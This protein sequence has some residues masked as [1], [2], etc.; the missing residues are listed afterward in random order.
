MRVSGG[1]LKN[2]SLSSPKKGG[3][4]RPTS[5]KLR[6]ALFN[7]IG[8]ETEGLF[9]L[10]LFAGSGSMGIEALSRGFFHVT[11]VEK[12]QLALKCLKDNVNNLNLNAHT[13]IMPLDALV[14]LKKLEKRETG[15]DYIYIDP[16][17]KD[18]K[19]R[20]TVLV[21]L[22]K[23]A[24]LLRPKGCIFVEGDS[25]ANLPQLEGLKLEKKRRFGSSLLYQFKRP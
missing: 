12:D 8:P 3:G 15:F 6:Q 16:P 14:S 13:T 7:I 17:Y 24:I 9:F 22:A 5:E 18:V 11:F 23:S 19:L 25:R 2:R 10:D 4:T 21:C 20:E 1:F